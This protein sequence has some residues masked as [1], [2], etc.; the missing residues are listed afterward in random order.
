[1]QMRVYDRRA[2]GFLPGEGC[3]F[4]VLRR[5]SDA[6]RDGQRVYALLRGWGISSDGRGA[7]T[8][9][10][11]PGQA[12]S[13]RRAY[14]SAAVPP[15]A[16]AFVEGHGTGTPAGDKVELTAVA[17]V[18]APGG[19][20][21]CGI[22]SLKSTVGHCKAA[23]GIG[24]LIKGVL[25]MHRRVVPPTAACEQPSPLFEPGGAADALYPVRAGRLLPAGQAPDATIAGVSAMGFGGINCH[26]VL[27]A[28]PDP[29]PNRAA[30]GLPDAALLAS[31]QPTE[32]FPLAAASP[33]ALAA[34][35]AALAAAA[36]GMAFGELADLAAHQ[37][38]ALVNPNPKTLPYR[39][40]VVA[41]SPDE[42]LERLAA[43]GAWLAAGPA[44]RP[45]APH[46][47]DG[48]LAGLAGAA[49]PRVGF[50]FPGQGSQRPGM[51]AGLLARHAWAREL[52]AQVGTRPPAPAQ[53]QPFLRG[54]SRD[55]SL[56]PCQKIFA[57]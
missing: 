2:N 8:A 34:Q 53:N 11:V 54:I 33:A 16:A 19:A 36:D 10:R 13:L 35:A 37:A 50:V 46:A 45:A 43:L 40:A 55:L 12:E 24:A 15:Q 25:A 29:H 21:S 6:A 42:L 5:A 20:A 57:G 17:S 56:L 28:A 39:A 4:L 32:V 3:G 30:P 49:P 51:A 7:I 41:G 9:P 38:G 27:G 22:T 52:T 23:A 47:G 31:W 26:I 14:A 1:M 48:W 18:M 44:W